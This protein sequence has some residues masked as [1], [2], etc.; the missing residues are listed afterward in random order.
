MELAKSKGMVIFMCLVFV[1]S[2]VSSIGTKKYD[3]KK[4]NENKESYIYDV[5]ITSQI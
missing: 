4:D 5:K 1:L 3:E 2:I